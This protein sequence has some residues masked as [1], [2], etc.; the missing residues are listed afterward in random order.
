MGTRNNFKT[1]YTITTMSLIIPATTLLGLIT[2]Y[3]LNLSGEKFILNIIFYVL[4]GLLIGISSITKN[5]KKF[6]NPSILVNEA[7][8]SIENN[9]FTYKISKEDLSSNNEMVNNLN[10]VIDNLK[11]MIIRVKNLSSNVTFSS[12]ENNKY[13]DNA[14]SKL[15][16]AVISIGEVVT[17]SSKQADSLNECESFISDLSIDINNIL[18]DMTNSKAFT[19]KALSTIKVIENT[20]KN[21]ES[22]MKDTKSASLVAV[23]SIKEFEIKSREISDIVGVIGQISEQTNLLALNASIEAARAG[24]YG[25]GF[26]VVADE[27]RKLAEQSANS[28]QN[29]GEIVKYIESAVSNTVNEITKVNLVVDDQSESLLKTISAFNEVSDIVTHISHDINKVLSSANILT[30]NCEETKNK[31]SSI[32]TFAEKNADT[33]EEV[34]NSI[35]EQLNLIH[36][37]KASSNDLSELSTILESQ[38]SVYKIN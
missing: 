13:L 21:A 8:T 36:K 5:I 28:V 35:N 9:D 26:S 24:E 23:N 1:K 33:T 16:E 30:G 31:I 38:L 11:S 19:E 12:N 25:K 27:I 20:V 22:K 14:I 15:Q 29:I 2:S 7:A 34:S 18:D 6:I 4:S 37:V 17:L 32:T 3:I 10:S